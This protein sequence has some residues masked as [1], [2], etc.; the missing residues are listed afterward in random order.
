M[1]EPIHTLE[2]ERAL[3]RPG[4]DRRA[5]ARYSLSPKTV[6]H[7]I[8][9]QL[10]DKWWPA[11]VRNISGSGMALLLPHQL[12]LGAPLAVD[13]W[14]VY[15]LLPARVIHVEPCGEGVWD[16]GC[17]FLHPLTEQELQALL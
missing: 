8:A 6:C 9:I 1:P 12:K 4:T 7:P 10:N 2:E 17:E 5:R 11:T 13:L 16:V 14:G 3:E 15:R